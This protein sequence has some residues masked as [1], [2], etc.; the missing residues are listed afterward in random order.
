MSPGEDLPTPGPGGAGAPGG[1][2]VE[3][4][5]KGGPP[6]PAGPADVD[7]LAAALRAERADLEVYERVLVGSLATD[8]AG[9]RSCESGDDYALD[10]G[11]G[12]YGAYQFSLSTWLGL[13]GSGLPSSAPP[14]V[15]DAAAYHLYQEVGFSAWPAC[16]AVLGLG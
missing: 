14:T 2:A 11:N 4:A 10:T 5:G 3:P 1:G 15:Q 12:Y 16:S 6:P 7:L 8:F 13:G 9:I